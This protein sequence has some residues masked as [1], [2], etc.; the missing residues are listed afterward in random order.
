M[1][2]PSAEFLKDA[3]F[4][5]DAS[6][7]IFRAYYGIQSPLTAPDGTPTHATYA[8]GQ[9]IDSLIKSH[10]TDHYVLLWDRKEKGFRH[11]IFEDY[12]ANRSAPPEDLGIQIE[13]SKAFMK[14]LGLPQFDLAGFE[15]DDLI[16]TL[17][18][19]FPNKNFVIVTSDK[20]LLQL[21]SDRVWCLDTLKEKW[22]NKEAAFEKFGVAPSQIK[23]VQALC[24][25]SV[26]NIP[27]A[28]GIGPKTAAQ[29]IVEFKSL[30]NVL[31]EAKKRWNSEDKAAKAKD[32]LKGK[33]LES[34]AENLDKVRLS[35]KLVSL[36]DN[37]PIDISEEDIKRSPI[38]KTK[39]IEF[40]K[41]LGFRK[42]AE[43]YE[44]LDLSNESSTDPSS[45][46]Q[47][48]SS[49]KR[50]DFKRITSINELSEIL[51]KHDNSLVCAL[52]T[53]TKSLNSR[54]AQSMV[55]I[56]LSFDSKTGYYIPLRHLDSEN[57]NVTEVV[58]VL[59]AYFDSRPKDFSIIFQ[60]AKFDLHVLLSDALVVPDTIRIEDTMIASFV[61]DPAQQHGMDALA[62]K[63]LEGYTPI[64]FKSVL[65]DR[66][67]FSQVPIEEATAYSAE[68][69]VVTFEL[70]EVLKKELHASHLWKVY[71]E[72]DRPLVRVLLDMEEAGI[73][74]DRKY[75][76]VLSERFH[77]DLE[78][79]TSEA[80]KMLKDFGCEFS[81]HSLNLASTKQMAQILFEQ[82]KLPII[83]KGKTGPSTDVSVL[84]E[85]SLQHPFP[86]LLLEFREISK[87]LSTYVDSLSAM[88][89]PKTDRLHTDFSQ[90]IAQTGRLASSNPNLQNIPI[91]STRGKLIRQAFLP[92]EGWKLMGFD[93]SQIE[94]RILAHMSQ[95]EQL[96]EAFAEGADIH[97]RTAS[98]IFHKPEAS[99]GDDERRAAK[100]I[101]FGIIYGQTPF[102]L[103]RTLK[104]SRTEAQKFIEN[105]FKSYP[106][107]KDYLDSMIDLARKKGFVETL[108]GRRRLLNDINSK[109]PP[110]RQF[111]ER[112]AVN[113]PLQGTAADLMKAA[114]IKV[115]QEVK[116]QK[117]KS[118]FLLQVHDELIFE[119]PPE[120]VEV[121]RK[122]VVDIMEDPD[123]LK[124]FGV[125]RFRVQMKAASEV[126]NHWGE[127]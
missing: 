127:I 3:I 37:A 99:L 87:L 28:P 32:I 113:S 58:K 10:P 120:E 125:E 105:Y 50:Y 13:N 90:T 67:D 78:E 64:S 116:N 61:I 94:L 1:S 39:L 48:Q 55:G 21:V 27:G 70:W 82:L 25:D 18:A 57:L 103:A 118:S 41:N 119:A 63:Y 38:D 86:E 114:M 74:I 81:E 84:E 108:T 40:A 76:R 115:H 65:G 77:K 97:R 124:P 106:K 91:R 85:L 95:A 104:V 11:E 51:K 15:A 92:R 100:T 59:R 123:L 4:L 6:S 75:L 102:G 30:E 66:D 69:A 14:L 49:T 7:Y 16:A 80:F 117:L 24:G 9:M 23:D 110:L 20:D 8:F 101:N 60:N 2:Q 122:L 73:H 46:I 42:L 88:V 68:D 29:L 44:K 54:Q 98:L 26:D 22:S 121:L 111:A 107:I 31:S 17:I 126:G 93:Y 19:K 36:S 62:A 43:K 109:N 34:I 83:K 89:D 45:S 96:I 56:S 112:M 52:D 12:K 35:L 53:E 72:L 79:T 47:S 33:K 5:V 71:D